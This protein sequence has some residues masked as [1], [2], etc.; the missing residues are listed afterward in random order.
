MAGVHGDLAGL[1]GEGFNK[2]EV[3]VSGEGPEDPE[4]GL[5]VLVVGFGGDVEVLEVALAVE[6][7]LAGLDLSVLLV[8]LV[9][10]EHDGD[11]VAD[12]G[13][14]LVPLGHVLVG[15][16]RSDVEH[17]NGGIGADIVA[18]PQAAQLLLASRVPEAELDG[19]VV[20]GED[21]RADLNALSGD[22]LLLEFSS[23]V[24]LDE[25]SLADTTISDKHDLENSHWL[26]L[27]RCIAYAL[28]ALHVL[29][30]QKN[31][32]AQINTNAY[33]KLA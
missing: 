6:G 20:G 14:V 27:N 26:N 3:G 33:H 16:S 15:D 32:N 2:V 22:V 5:L 8:D 7:D 18:L 9:S 10:D 17:Q 30:S 4:E 19:S 21:D 12:A 24:P 31:Y 25:G 13:E 23:D 1:E 28:S 11:V 29:I